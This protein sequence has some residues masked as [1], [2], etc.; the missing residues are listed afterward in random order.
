MPR[1]PF[2]PPVL[3]NLHQPQAAT[4]LTTRRF[5]HLAIDVRERGAESCGYVQQA[6]CRSFTSA[7]LCFCRLAAQIGFSTQAAERFKPLQRLLTVAPYLK[8]DEHERH[9]ALANRKDSIELNEDGTPNLIASDV[10]QTYDEPAQIRCGS[11]CGA[12]AAL[13]A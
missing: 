11:R 6:C 12:F 13:G 9:R 7:Q 5:L 4:G 2:P 1:F 8:D 10:T 3:T